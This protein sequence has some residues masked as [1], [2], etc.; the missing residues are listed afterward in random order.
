MQAL[1]QAAF[2]RTTGGFITTILGR[3]QSLVA[4]EGVS[5]QTGSQPSRGP[6]KNEAAD[7]AAKARRSGPQR[8]QHV[9]PATAAQGAVRDGPQHHFP[10]R[11]PDT[12]RSGRPGRGRRTATLQ[13]HYHSLDATQQQTQGRWRYS[14]CRVL[15]WGYCT[16]EELQG[17]LRGAQCAN[18]CGNA[19]P[20]PTGAL[21]PP[22]LPRHR[23]H[24]PGPAP[25]AQPA[26]WGAAE[27]A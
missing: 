7:A 10:P 8:H 19:H 9:L 20:S 26:R 25:R 22:V 15:R 6:R 16:R 13:H 11:S 5:G 4:Q 12:P 23:P 17:G 18:H 24:E 1:Q 2:P 3:L 21:P 27:W 14:Y